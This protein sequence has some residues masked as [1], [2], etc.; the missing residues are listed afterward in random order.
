MS[1]TSILKWLLKRIEGK[2]QD[3]NRG[4]AA[5]ILSILLQ[6]NRDN[7]LALCKNDGVETMLKVLSVG[8]IFLNAM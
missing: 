8:F 4:Y 5:E 1:K 2:K 7:R 3:E 6:N